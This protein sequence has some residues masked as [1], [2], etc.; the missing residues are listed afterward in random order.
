[1]ADIR[2]VRTHGSRLWLLTGALAFLAIAVWASVFFL[3]DPTAP[4]EERRVGALAD[5]GADRAPVLPAQAVPFNALRPVTERDLG[6]YVELR[7]TATTPVRANSVLVRADDGRRILVR[8]EPPLEG[9]PGISAGSSVTLRGYLRRVALA[10]YE[11]M[12]QDTL[13]HRIPRPPPHL[14]F[15]WEPDSAFL[16]LDRLYIKDYYLS[17]RPHGL[18]GAAA[19][20]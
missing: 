17:V 10:E 9:S 3:G 14:K 19:A 13:G 6:G 2:I 4:E 11:T 7:G 8:F 1:M 5:F 12:V 18:N 15:G 20:D 16:A